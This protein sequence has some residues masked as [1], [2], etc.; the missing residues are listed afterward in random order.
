MST[1]SYENVRDVLNSCDCK[2]CQRLTQ[3]VIDDG[4]P[5]ARLGYEDVFT[6]LKHHETLRLVVGRKAYVVRSDMC[7]RESDDVR[8]F[9]T[10]IDP[11]SVWNAL[12]I[13]AEAGK[14]SFE[15]RE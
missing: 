2:H 8:T 12:D 14:V 11:F 1:Q 6:P 15:V 10:A 7:Y 5:F 4:I 3:Y 9:Q 13:K